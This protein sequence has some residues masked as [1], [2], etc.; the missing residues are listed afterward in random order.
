MSEAQK[1]MYIYDGTFEGF[2][3]CVYNFY[4]NRLKPAAIVSVADFTPSFYE[5]LMIETDYEQVY[6]VRFAI[7][8]KMGRRNLEFLTGCFLTFLQ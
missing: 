8:E 4:Y 7:E 2:L 6:K 5:N 3:C 1:V